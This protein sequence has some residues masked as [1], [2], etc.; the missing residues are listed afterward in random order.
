MFS[1]WNHSRTRRDDQPLPSRTFF[2]HPEA[3]PPPPEWAPA[4]EKKHTLGLYNEASESDY[5]AAE[6]F[7]NQYPVDPARPLPS[8][9]VERI[10][11]QGCGAWTLERPHT[12]R[13]VGVI[14][15]GDVIRMRTEKKC[16]DVCA[17]SNLPIVG[18]WYDTKKKNGVYYEAQV[19][20]MDDVIA[21]GELP[22][23]RFSL[24]ANT[25]LTL[26]CC[27]WMSGMAC[28]PYPEFRLP[29]WNR[30]SAALHLD[31]LRKFCEDPDGGRDYALPPGIK[32][33]S[34]NDIIGCGY[35][36]S[37]GAIFF[38]HNGR[39]LPDAFTGMFLPRAQYDV[40]AAIG[41]CGRNEV[42]VNFG[43]ELFVWKEGN[44]WAWKIEGHVGMKL[45]G[46]SGAEEEDLPAYSRT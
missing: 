3:V 44:D 28:K 13:F 22:R 21:V 34:P 10:E 6:A 37:S 5:D 15:G 29:G 38:T 25:L 40:F 42:E 30:L 23:S 4:P 8:E 32:H 35:V 46:P 31:D 11:K 41:V 9:I 43:R 12:S 16:E 2:K 36:F 1:R 18:G 39:R 24:T 20:R 17:F 14:E 33:I 45:A 19:N 7:C 27:L 26:R